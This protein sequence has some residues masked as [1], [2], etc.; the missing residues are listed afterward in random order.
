MKKEIIIIGGG[1]AG[2]S[3]F[4][5]FSHLF[6]NIANVK[7][8]TSSNIP[9]VGVGEA[10][11]GHIKSFLRT[12][13][14][15]PDDFILNQC[16]GNI[17]YGVHL[18]DW[19]KDD[20]LYFTPVGTCGY[21][22]Y[23]YFNYDVTYKEMWESWMGLNLAFKNKSPF[24]KEEY[25]NNIGLPN[26]IN[27]YAYQFD[28]GKFAKNLIEKGKEY[29]GEIINDDIVELIS[30]EDDTISYAISTSGKKYNADLWIDC[31]GFHKLV[32]NS[33]NLEEK[34]F[35][36][37]NNNRAWATQL[38]Y[39]DRDTEFPYLSTVECQTMNAGW[40]WQ[41]G[42][43]ERIGTGYVF[44]NK[45]ISEDEALHEFQDSFDTG[46]VNKEKCHLIEFETSCLKRQCGKN[47]LSVGLSSGF[48]EPLESTSI[49]LMHVNIMAFAMIW[50]MDNLPKDIQMID[51]GM[52]PTD[53]DIYSEWHELSTKKIDT[54]NNYTYKLFEQTVNYIGSHYAVNKNNKSKYWT[55]WAE[56]REK[57]LP[58][59]NQGL[60][61]KDN[62]FFL[63][64]GWGLLA[65]G[66]Q[67]QRNE[68]PNW[69]I[70][71]RLEILPDGAGT[72]KVSQTEI[73]D[74]VLKQTQSEF[75]A[76]ERIYLGR[77]SHYNLVCKKFA[78][79]SYD[80]NDMYKHLENSSHNGKRSMNKYDY[81]LSMF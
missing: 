46:R 55:D 70:G 27:D 73:D 74:I 24:L 36:D 1:T 61:R 30:E 23:D 78:K 13:Q 12:V 76:K 19:Y 3:A 50:Q 72:D 81:L 60:L 15:D 44:S 38:N 53:P 42:L 8:I 56:K 29:G 47:W 75:I 71:R 7:M 40:R 17:K 67:L 43:K 31:S 14:L 48:V 59:I 77:L 39:I 10:T 9:T 6:K 57:Y 51:I 37:M 18:K 35:N 80:L 69:V 41:I 58:I 34:I 22:I 32:K 66:N 68:I 79:Y 4:I 26:K 28:A 52:Q 63:R 33:L 2:A 62:S 20:W 65:L 21:D 5:F 64:P 16:D 25:I 45:Y 11:V 49:F 54:F